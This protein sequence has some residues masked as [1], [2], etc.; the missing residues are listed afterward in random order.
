MWQ[1]SCFTDVTVPRLCHVAVAQIEGG[2][3]TSIL[4]VHLTPAALVGRALDY[5]VFGSLY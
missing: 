4:Y 2:A 3:A 5:M 1:F